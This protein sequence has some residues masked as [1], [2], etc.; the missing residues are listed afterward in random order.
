M[1][2]KEST[3][4]LSNAHEMQGYINDNPFVEMQ[5]FTV[6]KKPATRLKFY[7]GHKD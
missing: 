5:Y 7:I 1:T 2:K 6:V 3:E 4:K